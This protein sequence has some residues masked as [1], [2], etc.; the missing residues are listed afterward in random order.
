MHRVDSS[1]HVHCVAAFRLGCRRSRA[2][3]CRPAADARTRRVAAVRSAGGAL[4][5]AAQHGWL[6]GAARFGGTVSSSHAHGVVVRLAALLSGRQRL[7]CT[8]CGALSAR[9]AT[10]A[11]RLPRLAAGSGSHAR[12]VAGGSAALFALLGPRLA[13]TR[14]GSRVGGAFCAA[15]QQGWLRGSAGLG[16]TPSGRQR[17]ACA[18]HGAFLARLATL[19]AWLLGLPQ[20][21]A[22]AHTARRSG[23]RR[24]LRC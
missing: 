21:A 18:R 20:A 13:R 15:A 10:L 5:A 14:R 8:R 17:L 6:R 9:P 7:A 23:W 1:S 12:G 19:A 11:A 22:R 3:T 2:G 16:S 24:S 4:H